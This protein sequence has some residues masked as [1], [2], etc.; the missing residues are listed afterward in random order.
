MAI[1]RTQYRDPLIEKIIDHLKQGASKDIKNWYHGDV[2]LIQKRELP[3]VSVAIDNTIV[4]TDSTGDDKSTVPIV[5]SVITDINANQARDWDTMAG[6]TELYDIVAG[7]NK[8]FTY[9]KDSMIHLLRE[10]VHLASE[11]SEDGRGEVSVFLGIEDQP[12]QVEFG[13][14]VERR[15]AGIFSVEAAIRTSAFIYTPKIE[16][17]PL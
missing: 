10:K 7:R 1:K 14:G 17:A 4:T 8:D 15:G 6:T 5:I 16:T 9:R 12:L 2:L 13:I 3:A 11:Q